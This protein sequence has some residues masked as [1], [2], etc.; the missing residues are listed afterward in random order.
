MSSKSNGTP[1]R[2]F[3]KSSSLKILLLKGLIKNVVQEDR[4]LSTNKNSTDGAA[5]RKS[6]KLFEKS[7]WNGK[8]RLKVQTAG[9]YSVDG[10]SLIT[11]GLWAVKNAYCNAKPSVPFGSIDARMH[12]FSS[13]KDKVP[14]IFQTCVWH[15]YKV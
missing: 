11:W 15:W 8:Q 9:P 14:W 6:Q 10:C 3:T 4:E 13:P 12:F 2:G 1:W 7:S 5:N